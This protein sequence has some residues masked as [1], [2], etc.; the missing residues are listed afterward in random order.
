MRGRSPLPV[1]MLLGAT[2]C[3]T[4][5]AVRPSALA[6]LHAPVPGDAVVLTSPSGGTVRVDANSRI[7]FRLADGRQTAWM[8]VR[9][10]NTGDD[11]LFVRRRVPL[12]D[13]T[14]VDG[15]GLTDADRDFLE[16][17]EG[18]QRTSAADGV[19]LVGAGGRAALRARGEQEAPLSGQWRA[20]LPDQSWTGWMDG[21]TLLAASRRGLELESG[22]LWRDITDAEVRN[23]SGGKTLGLIIGGAAII[24]AVAALTDGKPGRVLAETARATARVTYMTTVLTVHNRPVHCYRYADPW[25][26][27]DA[28]VD[29]PVQPSLQEP[30]SGG[31]RLFTGVTRRRA[32]IE[33]VP[34]LQSMATLS[35]PE[36]LEQTAALSLRLAK[37][38]ELG[39]GLRAAALAA[40]GAAEPELRF[41][42]FGRAGLHLNLDANHRIAVPL[43]FDIGAGQGV[44]LQTRLNFGLR[45]RLTDDFSLGV[46]AP[47][48]T[49]TRMRTGLNGVKSRWS[50]PAGLELAFAL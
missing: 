45:I 29:G 49:L 15:R 46:S 19:Y 7:R 10:L 32:D 44:L 24:A 5:T 8:P 18:V 14:A 48:P 26:D 27:P 39:G 43:S 30:T 36:G 13:L 2:A 42:G 1:L 6:P 25:I 40:P 37:V 22:V 16:P 21:E 9:D 38:W 4:T 23:F 20:Q 34:S 35:A 28:V 17:W 33:V 12:A 41:I 3:T 47:S 50:F 31:T 11:G